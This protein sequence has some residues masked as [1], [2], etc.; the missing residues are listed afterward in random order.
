MKGLRLI[1]VVAAIV[2]GA[3]SA[4]IAQQTARL[5]RVGVLMPAAAQWDLGAFRTRLRELGYADGAN[6]IMDVRSAEGQ[7]DRLQALAAELLRY[8]PDAVVAVNTPSTRAMIATGTTLPIIMSVVGDPVALGF[9]PNLA[10][11]GGN[12]TGVS[13]QASD[14]AA[15]RLALF[16]E[17]VPTL[18]RVAVLLHPDEPIAEIEWQEVQQ[19]AIAMDLELRAFPVRTPADFD[20]AMDAVLAW[21]ADGLF[22][23][24][25]QAATLASETT[26]LAIRHNIAFMA[27]QKPA[28]RAGALLSYF[29]DAQYL[30]RLTADYVDRILK[31]ARPGD[32]PI[33]QPTKFELVINLKTA[34]ALGLDIPPAILARAD[35]VIE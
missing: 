18:K 2:A 14:L 27:L 21:R 28:V 3:S 15:K 35:E 9:V 26:Q 25:G 1:V 20:R 13:N 4:A 19:P 31:G 6:L 16:K 12:I 5:Y 10:R 17:A 11:P 22:R 23:L 32:L 30:Y 29:S 7:L 8:K 24:A 33:Q 34:K